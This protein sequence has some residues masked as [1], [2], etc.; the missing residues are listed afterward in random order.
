MTLLFGLILA[1]NPVAGSEACAGCH[2]EIY[3]RWSDSI[4]GKM[5]QP[6]TRKTV[7]SQTDLSGGPASRRFWRD[8][9]LY[10]EERGQ[11]N[12]IDYTLGN[13]RIQHYLTRRPNGEI[14]VLHSSWDVKRKEWFDSLDIVPGAPKNFVQ[15]WNT[16][17]LYCHVTQ[18][19][20]DV[21]GFNPKTG[22]YK[23]SWVESS[24][25][26]ERC[27]GPMAAHANGEKSSKAAK[28]SFDQLMICGQCH[29]AKTVTAAGF[30]TQKQYFDY[31][32][33]G[34]LDLEDETPD[35]AW[36]ADG[37]PR[38][39]S[40]EAAAFSLSG[41]FRSG[42]AACMSCHDPHWN[43]TDGNDELMKRPDQY[44]ANCHAQYQNSSHTKHAAASTGS[45]C[46]GCHMPFTVSGVKAKMRDHSIL[47]PEPEN[48]VRYSIPNACTECHT[49]RP[50]SWAAEKMAGWYP[51]RSSKIRLRATAFHLAKS[52]DSHATGPLIRLATDAKEPPLI[53]ASA[54]G[55]LMQFPGDAASR[56][57]FA[58][59]K[60]PDPMVRI[61]TARAL[62]VIEGDAAIGALSSLLN[63]GYRTVRVRAAASLVRLLFQRGTL[64]PESLKPA[65]ARGLDEY[66]QSLELEGDHPII[67]LQLAGLELF[68]GN[69]TAAREAY[70]VAVRLDPAN[71]D[72]YVGLALLD[73]R[74]GNRANAIKNAR[75]A[76]DVSGKEAYRK[77]LQQ[78][79][80]FPP[81]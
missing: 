64:T 78:M 12:R 10:I 40:N 20:Q 22:E 70:Q 79:Q 39:F 33:P 81:R 4:H 11:E 30:S 27:H 6:A 61:E 69:L 31:Y 16:S 72:A 60:D 34:L 58:L 41:C 43:R 17:C 63:D 46:V 5:I 66:R 29:W 71:A 36:W 25:T 28:S 7:V 42:K 49:D 76:A 1:Q 53:R 62:S 18:Q 32:L 50:A 24:A 9:K 15:Q 21:K 57:L 8:G 19:E 13:R 14:H 80:D 54:A 23:T 38:R 67:Q 35:P 52:K 2:T 26:C 75:K 47:Y 3:S 59:A 74:E 48:T 68:V 56:T 65:F 55:Y 51:S 77:F 45:S 44:C 73:V 37:R